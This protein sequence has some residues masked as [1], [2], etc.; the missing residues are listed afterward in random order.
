MI[1]FSTSLIKSLLI[2][3]G[4]LDVDTGLDGDVGDRPDDIRRGVEIQ[5]ALVDAHL[6]AVKRVGALTAGRL[7]DAQA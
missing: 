4:N 3:N 1:L 6:K 7:A 5:K 2:S